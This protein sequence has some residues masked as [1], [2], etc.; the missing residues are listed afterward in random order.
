ME[1]KQQTQVAEEHTRKR[2]GAA[3]F[4]ILLVVVLM[5]LVP[6]WTHL[7]Q[8]LKVHPFVW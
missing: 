1:G 5:F 4:C 6:S 2:I 3:V 7:V 8:G